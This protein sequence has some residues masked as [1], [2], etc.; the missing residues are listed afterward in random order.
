MS[1]ISI[2]TGGCGFIGSH[3]VDELIKR[4][5]EVIV[6]DHLSAECNEEF[7]KY[8][9]A[10]YLEE[11]ILNYG[12]EISANYVITKYKNYRTEY[13]W[14]QGEGN[15]YGT[16][17]EFRSTMFSAG[18]VLKYNLNKG[19][20]HAIRLKGGLNYSFGGSLPYF[21]YTAEPPYIIYADLDVDFTGFY[22]GLMIDLGA[23]KK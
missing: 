15:P 20:F 10:T 1:N 3:I 7:F 17:S 8:P 19:I 21:Y 23:K 18:L 4:G 14:S 22:G 5:H 12:V 2:V 11:S 16:T 13:M 6:I 9:N